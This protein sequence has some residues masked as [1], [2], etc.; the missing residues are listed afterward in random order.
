MKDG[1]NILNFEIMLIRVKVF[2]KSKKEEII[3]R[4]KD[5]F[6]I[7]IKEKPEKGI[8]T[9]KVKEILADY[10]NLPKEKVRLIKGSKDRSK[11]FEINGLILAK[12]PKLRNSKS[13]II[14]N[15]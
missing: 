11:I 9:K 13:K 1:R 2:P 8:A 4:S 7:K 14:N 12:T 10:Y 6:L 5:S 3:K 15:K